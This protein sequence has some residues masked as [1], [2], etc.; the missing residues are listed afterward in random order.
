MDMDMAQKIMD[1]HPE[2][3][4]EQAM[5]T[6][7]QVGDR[8]PGI[9][10][11]GADAAGN[12]RP[13]RA[14]V[15]FVELTCLLR[16]VPGLGIGSHRAGGKGRN[17]LPRGPGRPRI[18]DRSW[19]RDQ[20]DKTTGASGTS[21]SCPPIL[22]SAVLKDDQSVGSCLA[23]LIPETGRQSSVGSWRSDTYKRTETNYLPGR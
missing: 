17:T 6:A 20:P 3:D 7:R 16:V 4:R 10:R 1:E 22:A 23:L 2:A 13:L 11:R 8:L 18:R 9:G 14:A 5:A 21:V 15:P 19:R 12:G